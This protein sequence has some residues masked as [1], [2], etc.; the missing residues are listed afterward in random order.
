MTGPISGVPGVG[1][2]VD[3]VRTAAEV[4]GSVPAV[5]SR[6]A[7][8]RR[9]Q[10]PVAGRTAAIAAAAVVVVGVGVVSLAVPPPKAPAAPA[11]GGVQ[12]APADARTSSLFCTSGAGVDAGAGAT[13]AVALTNTSRTTVHGVMTTVAASGTA[14]IRSS[15]V[16]PPLGTAE[17]TPATGLPAGATATTFAFV[18]GGVTGTMVIGGPTGWSTAPCASTVAPQWEFAGGSTSSGLLD[19][20][21]YNPTAAQAVVDVSFLTTGGALLVPQAYQGITL[22]PGQLVVNGLG[23][24]VQGQAGVTTLVQATS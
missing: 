15:V 3:G 22:A 11:G 16:V 13:G 21:L 14:Q 20:S 4:T 9:A 17:V 12:V 10:R 19:L 8:R 5:Q 6:I 2:D 23:A 24:Y 18:G 1:D 7:R